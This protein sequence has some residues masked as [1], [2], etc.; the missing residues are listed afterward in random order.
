MYETNRIN[1]EK[2]EQL[3]VAHKKSFPQ[4]LE[5]YNKGVINDTN[6]LYT[7]EDVIQLMYLAAI[8]HWAN[9]QN[10]KTPKS[11]HSDRQGTALA[12][13]FIKMAFVKKKK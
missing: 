3:L 9:C 6:Y 13:R 10:Q 4:L 11:A 2:V 8:G 1:R 7:L 5:Q 12:K